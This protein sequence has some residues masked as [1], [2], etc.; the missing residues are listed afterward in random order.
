MQRY[1]YLTVIS[2]IALGTPTYAQQP[3]LAPP[4]VGGAGTPYRPNNSSAPLAP[5]SPV[6]P[7]GWPGAGPAV[8]TPRETSL[9]VT[10]DEDLMSMWLKPKDGLPDQFSGTEVVARV[11]SE[12]VLAS[13]VM[14]GVEEMI[15]QAIAAGQL[16]TAD[17]PKA[18]HQLMRQRL[19]QLM[20]TKMLLVEA[21]RNIPK[22]NMPKIEKR[23]KEMYD[24]EQIPK[25][26]DGTKIKSRAELLEAM[27]KAGTSLEDQ[28][29]QFLE[30]SLAAQWVHQQTEEKEKEITHDEMLAY[31]REHVTDFET[32]PRAR[33]EHLMVRIANYRSREE[34]Y[35]KLAEWGNQIWQGA[36]WAEVA[37]QHSD[38]LSSEHGGLHD[39][40]SQ[41]SLQ[42]EVLDRAIFM[43]PVGQ[44][45]PILSDDRGFHIVRVVARQELTRKTFAEVQAEV[46]KRIKA[47]REGV[48]MKQ[49]LVELRKRVP[50]WTIFDD[51]PTA[52]A[53]RPREQAY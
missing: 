8:Q 15:Q 52:T 41:G 3:P 44:L 51:V 35:A 43:L 29:R 9:P 49:Y 4:V 23:V 22:E 18:R 16:S 5:T 10:T 33:W 39:W 47:D 38:D 26:I 21:R 48:A 40:T 1:G 11:G 13:D 12:V 42:S 32:S 19:Q 14:S 25:M 7:E 2:A 46:K 50:V 36:P 30:R 37:K 45:S 34:A 20:D 6:R 53:S 31:Y 27:R 24:R 17:A 28:Q